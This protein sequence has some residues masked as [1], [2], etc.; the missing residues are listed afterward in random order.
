MAFV[1]VSTVGS[2]VRINVLFL[3]V[4]LVIRGQF[5]QDKFV[6]LFP[7]I[8]RSAYIPYFLEISLN[9][10]EHRIN[11]RVT[12]TEGALNPGP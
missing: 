1:S 8:F 4:N 11:S 10:L 9:S 12:F 5:A 2:Y 6:G 3:R 7:S